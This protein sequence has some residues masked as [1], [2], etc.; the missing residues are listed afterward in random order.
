M[1][2]QNSQNLIAEKVKA[3]NFSPFSK[4][5]QLIPFDRKAVL[6]KLA[7]DIYLEIIKTEKLTGRELMIEIDEVLEKQHFIYLEGE[8]IDH[9]DYHPEDEL[10]KGITEIRNSLEAAKNN[11]EEALRGID[12]M[13]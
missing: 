13:E 10:K 1:L 9:P 4:S 2:S 11:I 3:A 5:L 8:K 7:G 6:N 12:T